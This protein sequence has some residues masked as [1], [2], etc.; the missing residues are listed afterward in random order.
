MK[1]VAS[2]LGHKVE[3]KADGTVVLDGKPAWKVAGPALS[4]AGSTCSS[5]LTS[6]A[7]AF[8]GP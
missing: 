5:S 7:A 6:L 1:L 2:K 4:G 3:I 8:C